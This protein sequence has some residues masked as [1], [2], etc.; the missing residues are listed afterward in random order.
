MSD[1]FHEVS[2]S[3]DLLEIDPARV[4]TAGENRGRAE[5]T[6]WKYRCSVYVHVHT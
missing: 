1:P 5:W 4:R 6:T 3:S 2:G